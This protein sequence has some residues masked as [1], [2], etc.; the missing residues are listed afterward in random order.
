MGLFPPTGLPHLVIGGFMPSLL[1]SYY[2]MFNCYYWEVCSLKVNGGVV[3]PGERRGEGW[4]GGGER[5]E[6]AVRITV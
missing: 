4:Q 1:A 5:G 6:V 2:A 3:N